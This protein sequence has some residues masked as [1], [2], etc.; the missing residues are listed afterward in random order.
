[1]SDYDNFTNIGS[2]LGALAEVLNLLN[3][4]NS[5]YH[6]QVAY[7]SWVLA[8]E[9]GYDNDHIMLCLYTAMFHDVGD[10]VWEND[11]SNPFQMTSKLSAIRGARILQ[12]LPGYKSISETILYCNDR[13]AIHSIESQEETNK[14]N[15]IEISA[16]VHLAIWIS[17]QFDQQKP[18]LNQL[19]HIC[20]LADR[21]SGMEFMPEA[22]EALLRVQKE[23]YVWFNAMLNPNALR[24]EIGI[25]RTVSLEE[26]VRLTGLL[27]RIIDFRSPFTAMH[28]AGV[29]ASARKLA[30]LSGMTEEECMM[31]EI[32]G[33]LH[34]IG[35]LRVPKAILEKTGK[36]TEEEF[37]II[38][39]HAYYTSLIMQNIDGFEQ[40]AAWAGNHHEKLN[41]NGYP[42]HYDESQLDKG[43]KILAV[44]DIFS[45]ITEERPYRKGMSK[46]QV[47]DIMS[48][49]VENGNISNEIVQLLVEHYDEVNEVRNRMSK[50][51][52]KR[53]FDSIEST[54]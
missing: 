39:E 4:G 10:I 31:M 37:N 33:N 6:E 14:K 46:D 38:K 52:G 44:A 20:T 7:L 29:A 23:E 47:L 5:L 17:K 49:N 28:S 36:L 18:P 25:I 2:L 19:N 22:V 34:D 9:M 21:W 41:G 12:D 54:R 8:K 50:E 30:Q 3:P 15:Y 40:I 53:Y 26:T 1:M 45:A 16:V 51:I 11:G 42:F 27:S 13:W 48:M 35:K 43:S 32:A 24:K